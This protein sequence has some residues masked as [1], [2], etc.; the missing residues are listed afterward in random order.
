MSPSPG[1][2]PGRTIPEWLDPQNL[3]GHLFYMFL[4]ASDGHTLPNPFLVGR[5]IEKHVGKIE[6]AF[7]DRIRKWYVLKLRNMDQ[8]RKLEEMKKLIDGTPIEIGSHPNLNRRKFV[9]SCGEVIDMTEADLLAELLSQK[10]TEVRRITKKTPAG[11]IGTPTLVLTINSTVIPEFVNFGLLRVRTRLYIPQ[12]LLCRQCFSYGHPK[13][14]CPNERACSICSSQKHDSSECPGKKFCRTCQSHEHSPAERT[15]PKWVEEST[16][17]RIS[18]EQNLSLAAARQQI[19]TTTISRSATR[20]SP[21]QQQQQ[22]QPQKQ[23]DNTTKQQ[24]PKRDHTTVAS[25]QQAIP[26]TTP[27]PPRKKTPSS[28]SPSD[29]TDKGV[30]QETP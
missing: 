19:K 4:K 30:G 5:S 10:I 8:G 25:G 9:V 6:G 23:Q 14:R 2:H 24:H 29:S 17:L 18:A 13:K 22:Q 7:F 12:P 11:I 15:C 28:A 20:T 16:A 3:H 26:P 1:D 21:D 27:S